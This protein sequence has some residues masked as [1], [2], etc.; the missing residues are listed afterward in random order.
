MIHYTKILKLLRKNQGLTVNEIAVEIGLSK[1]DSLEVLFEME[2][3]GFVIPV[4]DP[5][6]PA[7]W[8]SNAPF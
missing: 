7:K 4:D 8:E 1:L 5:G 6:K 2:D 3:K